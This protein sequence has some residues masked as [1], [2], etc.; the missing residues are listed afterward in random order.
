MMGNLGPEE[1]MCRVLGA[2]ARHHLR[3]GGAVIPQQLLTSFAP[4][5]L[6][7]EGWGIWTDDFLGMRLDSVQHVLEPRAHLHFFTRRPTLLAEPA[8]VASSPRE[9]PSPHPGVLPELTVRTPGQLHAVLGYFTAVLAPGVT[10]SNFPSYPGCN[11]AVWVWPLRH[12]AVAVG[13]VLRLAVVPGVNERM[14]TDWRLDC[15]L[16][17]RKAA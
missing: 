2:V 5:E 13:D 12:T 17:R 10:L 16:L 6:D 7:G 14:A 3:P 8:V 15:H 1:D 4:A 11:W 9:T